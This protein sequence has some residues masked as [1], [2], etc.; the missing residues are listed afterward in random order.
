MSD[1]RSRSEPLSTAPVG[2]K[3]A[4][5]ASIGKPAE[6]PALTHIQS[7]WKPLATSATIGNY[8]RHYCPRRH[9]HRVPPSPLLP[10]PP[11]SPQQSPPP[12]SPP[13]PS[14]PPPL[15]HHP[16]RLHPR[17]TSTFASSTLVTTAFST[18]GDGPSTRTRLV[19]RPHAPSRTCPEPLTLRLQ[20]PICCLPRRTLN[21]TPLLTS[22]TARSTRGRMK[23]HERRG[24]R[25]SKTKEK[26]KEKK[27]IYLDF[28][29]SVV[30]ITEVWGVCEQDAFS[31]YQKC[32]QIAPPTPDTTKLQGLFTISFRSH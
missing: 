27:S 13:P 18:A 3:L 24:T 1:R 20:P 30:Y 23:S 6:K 14:P 10:S 28:I 7:K 26:N 9:R 4:A 5:F 31:I 2:T 8:A 17:L 22:A 25:E 16:L 15:P 11:P 29:F 32:Q 19:S 21:C 12:P